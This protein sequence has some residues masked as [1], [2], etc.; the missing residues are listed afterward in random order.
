[1]REAFGRD[2]LVSGDPGG[3]E[4]DDGAGGRAK[5][6][7]DFVAGVP[8][9]WESKAQLLALYSRDND[10]LSGRT[11]NEKREILKRTSYRDFLNRV[12]GCDEEVANCFQG[13]PLGFFGLGSDSVAAADAR[14][15]GYPGFAGLKLP[16][17]SN[18]A[19]KG[20]YIYTFPHRDALA[21][22]PRSRS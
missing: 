6:L 4:G 8:H 12:W 21:A 3:G 13:R 7:A 17:N 22:P 16:G 20:P 15:L 18:T 5:K 9:S 2:V 11:A 19:R 14:D 10:P 1:N